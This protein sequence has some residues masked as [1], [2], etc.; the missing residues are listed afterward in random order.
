MTYYE[1]PEGSYEDSHGSG[2][3]SGALKLVNREASQC[4][5]A[6]L[7]QAH[8][9]ETP[10]PVAIFALRRA[11]TAV[12]NASIPSVVVRTYL[13]PDSHL[14]VWHTTGIPRGEGHCSL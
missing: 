13:P 4:L 2:L 8:R 1:A 3:M 12:E 6:P 14:G 7:G 11:L 10:R 5:A 9:C